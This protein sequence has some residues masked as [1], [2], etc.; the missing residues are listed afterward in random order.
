MPKRP[1]DK[2]RPQWNEWWKPHERHEPHADDN[3]KWSP[4]RPARKLPPAHSGTGGGYLSE[5]QTAAFME[6]EVMHVHSSNVVS[7]QYDSGT[8][9]MT[10]TFNDGTYLYY[11]VSDHE[12]EVFATATSKGRYIW[13]YFRVRG[14]ATQH[15]KPYKKI[16]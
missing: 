11:G 13:D 7:A 1:W 14:S 4:S 16:S 9:Q 6:G 8:Q 12:A 2:Y 3:L 5:E 15:K 10:V